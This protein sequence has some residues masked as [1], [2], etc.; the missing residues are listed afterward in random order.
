MWRQQQLSLL[1]RKLVVDMQHTYFSEVACQSEVYV[2]ETLYMI[3]LKL[4]NNC[5]NALYAL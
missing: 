4:L 2:W 1:I 3:H 5:Q